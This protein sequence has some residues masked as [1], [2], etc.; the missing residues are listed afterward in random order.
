LS[1]KRAEETLQ[2]WK[3]CLSYREGYRRAQTLSS[4]GRE[5]VREKDER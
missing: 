2:E 4:S 5:D 3:G 1:T